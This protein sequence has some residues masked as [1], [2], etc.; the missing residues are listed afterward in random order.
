[1]SAMTNSPKHPQLDVLPE[2]PGRT[3]AVLA[4]IDNGPHVI[5]VSAPVRDGDRRILL[6]LRRERGSVARIRKDASVALTVLTEGN[7]AFTARGRARIAEE[8]ME[9]D[10]DYAAIAIDVEEIDDH[11]QQAF[12]VTGGVDRDWIDESERS[13]LGRRVAG[14][15]A[16]ASHR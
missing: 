12:E 10:P 6:S 13:A 14:L 16:L 2:W 3:I 1:V 11:R 7:V 9:S 8:A 4:T 15:R 5:P